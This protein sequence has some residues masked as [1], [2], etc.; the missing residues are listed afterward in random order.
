MPVRKR[1][2]KRSRAAGAW[3]EIFEYGFDM[4]NRA[5]AA[6][7]KL[8]DRLEP[9]CDEALAAWHRYGEQFL[10]DYPGREAPW[11][12]TEFGRPGGDRCQLDAR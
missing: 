11:A 2:D 9:R 4:L 12:L 10:A 6:G 5:H 3:A 7:I 1:T 8:N